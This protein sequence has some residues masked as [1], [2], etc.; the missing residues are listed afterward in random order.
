[1]TGSS[2]DVDLPI[3]V[4]DAISAELRAA[5]A[6]LCHVARETDTPLYLVGGMVRDRLLLEEPPAGDALDLDLAVDADPSPLVAALPDAQ[7]VVHDR[8]GSALARL[9]DGSRIDLVPTRS[10]RY[11]APAALPVVEPA[12]I[13]ADLGRRDFTINAAAFA[14]S[15]PRS[16]ALLDPHEG[17]RDAAR[18]RLRVLHPQSFRDDPT[19]LIRLCR[20][21]ARIAGRADTRTA[22]L[23]REST[24]DP[25]GLAALT[26]ARFGDAW[27]AL[28]QDTAAA[29]ALRR[30]RRLRLPQARLAGWDVPAQAGA[31][32]G[33]GDDDATERFW[34][35]VGL[36]CSDS[37]IVTQLP[38]SAALRRAERA[39]L[40]G[41]SAL[42]AAKPRIARAENLSEAA[43]YVRRAPPT[44]QDTAAELWRGTAAE[45]LREFLARRG[46]AQAPLSG[47]D[48]LALGVPAGPAVGVWQRR[49]E[50]AIWDDELPQDSVA[51]IALAEQWV[52]SSPTAPPDN[53]PAA[54]REHAN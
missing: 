9:A 6:S 44:V 47:G 38:R 17:A 41:S 35:A 5:V 28:L 24:V 45:R 32:L 25:G 33:G 26:P 2:P 40:V 27:R 49:L 12:P 36:T 30:A 7:W 43:E 53:P 23:A 34:A 39:A 4:A 51:R 8:F 1:M 10:E 13:D 46:C 37:G 29:E 21:A 16:G 19:R 54:R 31:V 11:P 15:G 22:R 50:R 52:R 3:A 18:R 20:Y 48:L 42:R 14:L